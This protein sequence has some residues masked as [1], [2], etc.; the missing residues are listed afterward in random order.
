VDSKI[1]K[2]YQR[3]VKKAMCII[4]LNLADNQLVYI[5]S[6][7]VAKNRRGMEEPLLQFFMYNMQEDEIVLDH[8]NKL[9]TF[10]D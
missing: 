9:K 10:V 4:G 6:S 2:E 3:R 1:L 8:I 7:K 5:K